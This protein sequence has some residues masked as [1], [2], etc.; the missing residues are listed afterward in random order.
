M[1]AMVCGIRGVTCDGGR[2]V[3]PGNGVESQ[4]R[5]WSLAGGRCRVGMLTTRPRAWGTTGG[6]GL[7]SRNG[8]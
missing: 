5:L 1:A 2:C 3:V 4:N 6:E 7:L 8:R